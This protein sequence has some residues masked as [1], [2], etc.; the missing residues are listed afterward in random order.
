M[1]G[2]VF[3]AYT[4]G[5]IGMLATDEGYA[6]V[7]G[8]FPAAVRRLLG[9]FEDE[10]P[11]FEV[12]EFDPILDSANMR[13]ADWN[14]IAT[15]IAER[16]DEFDGFVVLHGTDTLAYTASALSFMLEGLRKPVIV[17]GSQIP[18]SRVRS[19]AR[20][21]LIDALL[22]ASDF[23]IPEVGVVFDD[24]LYRGNRATK[25]S[26]SDLNAFRSPNYPALAHTGTRI[27]IDHDHVRRA[28]RGPL[29]V[30]E[31]HDAHVGALRLFPGVDARVVENILAP[32]LKGLVLEA[33]GVGNAPVRD[34]ELI[35]VIADA[36]ARGVVIAVCSQCLEGTVDLESYATGRALAEAGAVGVRDM[37]AEATMAKL[38]Y[39][40]ARGGDPAKI[41]RDMVRDLRGELTLP[42]SEG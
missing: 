1:S 23:S 13:P 17:T 9:D 24:C 3:V 16:Y 18:F 30:Q 38:L 27:R 10:I 12:E 15:T 19:D 32:P 21:N 37:T 20:R 22:L 8:A 28:P 2:R 14:C 11:A 7:P 31:I 36:S 42:D 6:P 34:R 5:T 40:L 35:R 39:L 29:R 4:G 33:Y 25:V 41:R 26:A